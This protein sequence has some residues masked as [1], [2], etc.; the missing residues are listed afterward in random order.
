[1]YETRPKLGGR[2]L[3]PNEAVSLRS[4]IAEGWRLRNLPEHAL[5]R[6]DNDGAIAMEGFGIK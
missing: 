5:P 1:L 3:H 2:I 4:Q 6:F